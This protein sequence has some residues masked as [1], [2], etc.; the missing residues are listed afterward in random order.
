[1]AL[2]FKSISPSVY[3]AFGSIQA[4]NLC[5][6]KGSA[7][8]STTVALDADQ[9]STQR[10][11]FPATTGSLTGDDYELN[12][13]YC[14]ELTS[15][16]GEWST[17]DYGSCGDIKT[18]WWTYYGSNDTTKYSD[19]S[20]FNADLTSAMNECGLGCEGVPISSLTCVY[21]PCSPFLSVPSQ[22]ASL[23]PALAGCDDEINVY[24][25]PPYTLSAGNGLV[26]FSTTPYSGMPASPAATPQ[27][28]IGSP[29]A[30]PTEPKPAPVVP[31]ASSSSVAVDSKPSE[32][33]SSSDPAEPSESATGDPDPPAS[34]AAGTSSPSVAADPGEPVTV[35]PS[36]QA[37]VPAQASSPSVPVDPIKSDTVPAVD[38]GSSAQAPANPS[39]SSQASSDPRPAS[40]DSPDPLSSGD[41]ATPQAGYNPV[42]S[43][44]I[45]TIGDLTA[46][47]VS[48][49]IIIGDSTLSAG[50]DGVTIGGTT[51]S[52]NP[53]TSLVVDGSTTALA[54]P[55]L[56]P[57]LVTISSTILA[58]V[59]SQTIAPGSV[60]TIDGKTY[61][62][63][64]SG[65][66]LIVDGS[67][68]ALALPTPIPS[69]VT[70][71]SATL[72]V[73]G[74][75]TIVPGSAAT[76]DG[77]TYSLATDG[78]AL[79]VDGTSQYFVGSQ[80]LVAGGSAI[81]VSGTVL[82]LASGGQS[83]VV[84]SSTQAIGSFFGTTSTGLGGAIM[85]I[86]GFNSESGG[87]SAIATATA[88]GYNGTVFTGSASRRSG[89]GNIEI[90]GW[91]VSLV[92]C[93]Q[94]LRL[95]P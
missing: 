94:F 38:P 15:P 47:Q 41:P 62:L 64:T 83:V 16:E 14:A 11:Y 76:I 85:S 48:S 88:T 26:A 81:I 18:S 4:T 84:G 42:T 67:T 37:T 28:A 92:I 44:P 69:L 32:S 9:L 82:S 7:V 72:V 60:A 70:T 31:T 19:A 68:T 54:F 40:Q 13:G 3:V 35:D 29:T 43:Q 75:Q 58:I 23:N 53:S 95:L 20:A 90:V 46:S 93:N 10:F 5:G 1:M 33:S 52:L 91:A 45:A 79:V 57:S 6:V 56:G 25:D 65:N 22:V 74:S 39:V 59:G 61:S 55:K 27:P 78:N 86:G 77:K 12:N 17:F 87:T 2:T 49:H 66:A 71:S 63:A 89:I 36:H 51:F 34:P 8:Y 21:N 24:F 30:S 73:V 80:T 50:G